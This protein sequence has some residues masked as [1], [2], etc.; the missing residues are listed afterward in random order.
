MQAR[1]KAGSPRSAGRERL[2]ARS[3]QLTGPAWR[4]AAN[5]GGL[6]HTASSLSESPASRRFDLEHISR[7]QS[8]LIRMGQRFHAAVTSYHA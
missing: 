1:W 5:V 3:S 2:L 4:G 7:L 6:A 8:R